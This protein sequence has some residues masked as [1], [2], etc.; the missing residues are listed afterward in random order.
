MD[1]LTPA[2]ASAS[3]ATPVRDWIVNHDDS[4]AFVLLYLVLALVLSIAIGLFWLVALVGVH[5]V[6]EY[7]RARHHRAGRRAA[8]GAALWTL[9]LDLALV[10]FALSLA[11]Y[12]KYVFG[13]L[14]IAA[15]GRAASAAQVGVKTGARFA[16]WERVIHG[17]LITVDDMARGVRAVVVLRGQAAGRG[18]AAAAPAPAAVPVAPTTGRRGLSLGDRLTLAFGAVCLLLILAAPWLGY[19][20]WSEAFA[21]LAGELRPFPGRG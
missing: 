21:T 3:T 15:A 17:F 16:A 20:S 1:A 5:F 4:R 11:L 12:L 7:V 9:K 2:A 14:G 10:L 18:G 13:V 6:F 8:V 19:G